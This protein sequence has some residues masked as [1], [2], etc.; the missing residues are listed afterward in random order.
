MKKKDTSILAESAISA[1]AKFIFQ[2]NIMKNNIEKIPLKNIIATKD[3]IK[4]GK[5]IEQ[6][7][8]LITNYKLTIEEI[9]GFLVEN[10]DFSETE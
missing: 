4:D 7:F 5:L 2:P 1:K 8:Y 9:A 10:K 6:I 3:S